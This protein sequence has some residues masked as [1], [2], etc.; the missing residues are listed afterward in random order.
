MS[1]PMLNVGVSMLNVGVSMLNVGVSMLNVS[2]SILNVGV[3][4]VICFGLGSLCGLHSP[5]V[6][7][8]LHLS[9]LLM[10][11]LGRSWGKRV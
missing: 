3:S 9:D 8:M 2:V 7:S 10:L 6:P 4:M 5:T 1:M 11:L